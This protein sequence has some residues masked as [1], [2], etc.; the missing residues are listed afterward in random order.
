MRNKSLS[1][2]SLLLLVWTFQGDRLAAQSPVEELSARADSLFAELDRI[3]SPGASVAVFR[4]GEI[5]FSKGYGAANLEYDAPV[6]PETMFHVAS[7]SKQFTAFGA[8]LLAQQGKLSLDDD[9]RKH[10]P[11]VP[12][13]GTPI[14][15]R[16]LIHHTSGLRD[17]WN[18]LALAGWRLDDVITKE[19]VLKLISNQQELNF[20][21]GAEHLYCN[22]GYTLLAEIVARV[23]G[24]SFPEFM[25]EQVFEPLGMKN[26]LFYDDHERIVKG[27]AYSYYPTPEGGFNKAVL[28]YA[29]AGATS[30]FTTAEDQTLWLANLG[31]GRVG[32]S[33][34]I[35]QMM[36]RGVLNS[37]DT[38]SYAFGLVIGNYKGLK[39]VGHGGGDA[40]YRS[41]VVFFPDAN[42]G[43]AV[44]SNLASLIPQ[45]KTFG[46]ADIFLEDVLDEPGEGPADAAN[47]D[48]QE[49]EID[50]E[51]FD[52]Y[53][54]DYALDAAPN[55]ILTFYS[56][57]GRNYIRA[58]GQPSAEL[59][60][61]SDTTFFMKVV[62]AEVTF[63]RGPDGKVSSLTLFQG[64]P[65]R[66]KRVEERAEPTPEELAGFTGRYYSP[67]LE[68]FY[69]V[70]LE[71]GKLIARH[72]RH[73][74]IHLTPSEKDRFSGDTWFFSDV[75]FERD[76]GDAVT[77]MRV[78]SG[79]VRNV[80]FEKVEL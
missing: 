80:R 36:E 38:L 58:T 53:A 17:Q 67:E 71:G 32:G 61:S 34:A 47:A 15:I 30:L 60:A 69:T 20:Q 73:S 4:D 63:H 35:D 72:Q 16:H 64:G 62:D 44:L 41:D 11:E 13:F 19:H 42:A 65:N 26:T 27:R 70:M 39:V 24:Q 2:L 23:S 25:Q 8:V 56:E 3:D 43:I 18:L 57:D 10:L 79:R 74:D 48:Q 50:P 7:V 46:L 45:M 5:V 6:T 76:A 9:I 78:S 75:K 22:T 12:D 28:S 33:A 29:N 40:G 1:L 66:A 21:P 37:G 77:T 54:G 55:F 68:T 31:T 49:V 59:F 51:L 14:T 52:A